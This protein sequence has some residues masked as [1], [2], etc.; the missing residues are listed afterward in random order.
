MIGS[1][2]PKDIIRAQLRLTHCLSPS[3]LNSFPIVHWVASRS[4]SIA[5]F[6]SFELNIRW[7]DR[8][9][10]NWRLPG[11]REKESKRERER[12][13]ESEREGTKKDRDIEK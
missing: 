3:P 1:T 12:A 11:D 13:G 10:E 6:L 9:V 4:V 7:Q 8:A 5:R 2:A